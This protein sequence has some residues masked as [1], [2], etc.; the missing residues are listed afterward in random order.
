MHRSKHVLGVT[1]HR[2]F[3]ALGAITLTALIA[4]GA[5]A[6]AGSKDT[7]LD[8]KVLVTNAGPLPACSEDGNNCTDTNTVR[9]FIRIE[10]GNALI[11]H[12]PQGGAARA[13]VPN[14]F[15]VNSIDEAIFVDGVQD[16][17][18]DFTYTP[19][20]SPSLRAYSGH[21][22]VSVTCPP[23]GPPCT[24]VNSNPAVLPGEETSVFWT[25]WAHGDAESNGT[26]IFKFTI[27]GTLN[28]NA[29]DLTA[30]TPPI[31]MTS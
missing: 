7:Q 17:D 19:P 31:V 30:S 26:Y 13:D 8:A 25:G 12:G 24:N 15:V 20:P 27:H 11:N 1:M 2:L 6:F 29:V 23:D 4:G 22:V 3:A 14:A 21:W 5:L 28:G 16:H 9:Q 18:F 10:N